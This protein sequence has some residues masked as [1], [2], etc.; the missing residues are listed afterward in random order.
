M[1]ND[2]HVYVHDAHSQDFANMVSINLIPSL[3]GQLKKS[4]LHYYYIIKKYVIIIITND[5]T[6]IDEHL[7][8]ASQQGALPFSSRNNFSRLLLKK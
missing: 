1:Y 6:N 7:S 2:T 4:H 5:S 8:L 3:R